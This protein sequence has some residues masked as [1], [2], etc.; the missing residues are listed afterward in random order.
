MKLKY[1]KGLTVERWKEFPFFKQ[2]L[3]IATELNRAGKWIKAGDFDECTNS[4]G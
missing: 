1:R 2:I 3:M 4:S